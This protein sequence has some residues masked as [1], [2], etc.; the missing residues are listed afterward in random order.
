LPVGQPTT[1]ERQLHAEFEAGY[2]APPF[3]DPEP[4][5]GRL[6]PRLGLVQTVH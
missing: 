6:F 3:A 4:L 1:F 5:L 2:G